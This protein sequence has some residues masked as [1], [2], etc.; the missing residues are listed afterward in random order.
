MKAKIYNIDDFTRRQVEWLQH[1]AN[2]QQREIARLFWKHHDQA[3][4]PRQLWETFDLPYE[5]NSVRRAMTNL[6]DMQPQILQ[7]TNKTRKTVG[8]ASEHL[9]RWAQPDR[10]VY[11]LGMFPS[12]RKEFWKSG[13]LGEN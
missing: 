4:G 10:Q 2:K 6:T 9:W 11:Q 13:I 1:Q 3:F 7:K 12:A 5:L 8:H